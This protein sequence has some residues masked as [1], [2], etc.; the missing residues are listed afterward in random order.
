MISVL[1][2]TY[3]VGMITMGRS[4]DCEFGKTPTFNQSAMTMT[5]GSVMVLSSSLVA[6]FFSS[7]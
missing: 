6:L 5:E 1:P 7:L 3:M 4:T 2:S